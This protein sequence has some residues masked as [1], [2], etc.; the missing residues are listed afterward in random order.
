MNHPVNDHGEEMLSLDAIAEKAYAM[1]AKL[2]PVCAFSD[3]FYFFPQVVGEHKN[4]QAWDDFSAQTVA[5]AADLLRGTE[6]D[7]TRLVADD[8]S[9]DDQVDVDLLRQ[10]LRTLREQLIEVGPHRSQPSFHLTVLAAGF[11][12]ALASPEPRAW[13]GRVAG[14]P[15]FLRRAAE[16]LSEVPGVFLI[17]GAEMLHDIQRWIER[18][19]ASG[20]DTGEM[21]SA[22]L[23]FRDAMQQVEV[24]ESPLLPEQVLQR[25]IAEHIGS[26]MSIESVESLLHEELNTM[27]DVLAQ[28]TAR[29]APGRTWAEAEPLIP[30]VEATG[31]DLLAL[32]RRE[33]EVIEA[34]CRRHGLVP[35]NAPLAAP[36]DIAPVPDYLAAI[37]ASDAY[38]ATPGFP[39][40]GG[41]FFVMEQ[42]RA[43]HGRPGRSLEYRMTAV[44]EAWPGH[45]LLDACRWQLDR[46]LRRPVES[47]LFYEGWACLAEEMMARTG[48]FAGPWDRFLL[49][50]RRAERAARG[51]IDCGLQSGRMTFAQAQ[52]L[53]LRVGYSP[54]VAGSVVP[55]Y[56]LRPGYQIC[57]TL[58]L[59]QGL[60]LLDRFGAHDVGLFA[61]TLLSQGEIGFARLEKILPAA[62]QRSQA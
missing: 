25:L 3:E 26:G 4:W 59:Q 48:Y 55:K 46:P 36:L 7:L 39:P 43:R 41:V 15:A 45:H 18:L 53:L 21:S 38:A 14:A 1:I 35:A 6:R 19:Q 56:L 32:Y 27:E 40:R 50:K 8:L 60:D 16:C 44:H 52:E 23:L 20:F 37:R 10:L 22:L 62:L 17:L 12:E 28:E 11:A 9:A 24:I 34:H 51:L 58:G 29:L 61:R 31:H 54:A 2:F 57:Y 5:D 30:F 49:A 47:P 13:P 42:A 33:L